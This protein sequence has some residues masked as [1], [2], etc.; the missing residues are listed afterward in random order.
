MDAKHLTVNIYGCTLAQDTITD[1]LDQLANICGLKGGSRCA[2]GYKTMWYIFTGSHMF[3]HTWDNGACV[4]IVCNKEGWEKPVVDA[5][6]SRFTG[7][8]VCVMLRLEGAR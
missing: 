6:R 8:E 5:L 7:A 2:N 1:V 3:M 4:D